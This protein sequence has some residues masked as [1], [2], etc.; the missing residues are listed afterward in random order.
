MYTCVV[1]AYTCVQQTSGRRRLLQH[2][3]T[4]GLCSRSRLSSILAYVAVTAHERSPI[5]VSVGPPPCHT[6]LLQRPTNAT[7]P[8]LDKHKH[9]AQH[10]QSLIMT[11]MCTSPTQTRSERTTT[12]NLH[13]PHATTCN[14]QQLRPLV[15][16]SHHHDNAPRQPYGIGSPH[17]G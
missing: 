16:P 13:Q 3:P 17:R 8:P 1:H 5:L 9:A 7:F 14:H 12:C 2:A 4:S 15:H 6:E 10:A 11:G